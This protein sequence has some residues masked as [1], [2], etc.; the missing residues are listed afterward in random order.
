MNIMIVHF[1]GE[2]ENLKDVKDFEFRTNHVANWVRVKFEDGHTE[3]IHSIAT[4]KTI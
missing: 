1:G 4:I 2:A 3:T